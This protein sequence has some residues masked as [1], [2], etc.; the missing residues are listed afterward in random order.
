MLIQLAVQE[1]LLDTK[2]FPVLPETRYESY[3]KDLSELN[4]SMAS[5]HTRLTTENRIREAALSLA[6]MNAGGGKEQAR[7]AQEQ[8]ANASKKVDAVATELWKTAGR[9]MEIERHV[10]KHLAAVLRYEALR[11]GENGVGETVGGGGGEMKTK[12]SSAE[13]KIKEQETMIAALKSTV[14]RLEG[15]NEE[16]NKELP[17]LRS[18]KEILERKL[19]RLER[20]VKESD[21]EIKRLRSSK[22]A[23]DNESERKPDPRGQEVARLKLEVERWKAENEKSQLENHVAQDQIA[24]LRLQLEEDQ[25]M[26]ESKDRN[27][28]NLM[29]EIEM[30]QTKVDM[31]AAKDS[32]TSAAE[33]ERNMGSIR[34]QITS[35]LNE[36][37]TKRKSVFGGQ[38]KDAVMEREKLKTELREEKSKVRDLQ[39]KV[40]ELEAAGM[41]GEEVDVKENAG[42]TVKMTEAKKQISELEDKLKETQKDTQTL[43]KL[44]ISIVPSSNAQPTSPRS[45]GT[46]RSFANLAS[47]DEWSASVEKYS[48][49]A[50]ATH[51][52]NMVAERDKL[53][54]RLKEVEETLDKHLR[55]TNDRGERERSDARSREDNLSRQVKQLES[56]VTKLTT[57]LDDSKRRARIAEQKEAERASEN[58]RTELQIEKLRNEV[59]LLRSRSSEQEMLRST[60]SS[61]RENE[62]RAWHERE[63]ENL[64]ASLES[65]M[66]I[67]DKQR[68]ELEAQ[69]ARESARVKMISE[70]LTMA[71]EERERLGKEREELLDQYASAEREHKEKM[72]R[73]NEDHREEM[74][75]L[76]VRQEREVEGAL[77]N[78]QREIAMKELD[79][80]ASLLAQQ[81]TMDKKH[82]QEVE[83]L[84]VQSVEELSKA[85][86]NAA[87]ERRKMQNETE[88]MYRK[89]QEDLENGHREEVEALKALQTSELGRIR[90]AQ[91]ADKQRELSRMKSEHEAAIAALQADMQ[92]ALTSAAGKHHEEI[93]QM[94]EQYENELRSMQESH[95]QEQAELIG[96]L[97][98]SEAALVAY[99][100]QHFQDRER[101]QESIDEL[102]EQV[103]AYKQKEVD[104]FN[105]SSGKMREY[106]NTINKMRFD[107]Q[108]LNAQLED[109]KGEMASKD[110]DRAASEQRVAAQMEQERTTWRDRVEALER[111]LAEYEGVRSELE[112]VERDY[113]QQLARKDNE[114]RAAEAAVREVREGEELL[115][116]QLG[117]VKQQLDNARREL[118]TAKEE[119]RAEEGR[120]VQASMVSEVERLQMQV[121]Q[122]KTQKVEMLE[123]LDNQHHREQAMSA[124]LNAMRKEYDRVTR[125]MSNFDSERRKLDMTIAAQKQE[126]AKLQ[127]RVQDSGFERLF[128]S[129]PPSGSAGPLS[130]SS[131]GEDPS[132][133]GTGSQQK[134]RAEFRKMLA[135]VR[136]EYTAQIDKEVSTRQQLESELRKWKK[137]R[138]M[139]SYRRLDSGTQTHL[140]WVESEQPMRIH[141]W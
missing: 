43:K 50:L 2:R 140:K 14:T 56:E 74:E 92:R 6:K 38:L 25:L 24:E 123:E 15:E 40:L 134:L 57:Q 80:E 53:I 136:S 75:E 108:A 139:E 17:D 96:R 115:R 95:D 21:E 22:E 125:G 126:I 107:M 131:T 9:V 28:S 109:A 112:T 114:L 10:L 7:N 72:S 62:M 59:D 141:G 79:F 78:L 23:S 81:V 82:A 31:Y 100:S 49:E 93:S 32:R 12:L 33:R 34:S 77:E 44:F 35:Q 99:K 13:T 67:V 116:A 20:M 16:M 120:Q 18:D 94:K 86:E 61:R 63:L 51:A 83:R 1:A 4:K 106:E 105:N 127:S 27:I 103:R 129:S 128:S 65:E 46:I 91:N 87:K 42:Y 48:A 66:R 55:E 113:I 30:L 101:L 89:R 104:Q 118:E 121:V 45:P 73:L 11:L 132:M 54:R 84:K 138:E 26:V 47:N 97:N 8:L 52:N 130:S 110:R 76:M 58:S 133:A 39:L 29:S 98:R 124:E 111:Q 41:G 71:E 5:L 3:K 36:Q 122:L 60:E 37:N 90:E 85:L 70:K 102:E 19:K 69:L 119:R 135:D 117:A 68:R 88:A 64:R 137:D